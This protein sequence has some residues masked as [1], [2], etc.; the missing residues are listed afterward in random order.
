ME[1]SDIFLE[2]KISLEVRELHRLSQRFC[3]LKFT[4]TAEEEVTDVQPPAHLK[5]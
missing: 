1:A 3:F 2:G 5:Y 4:T